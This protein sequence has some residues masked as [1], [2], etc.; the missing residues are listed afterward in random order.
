MERFPDP[1]N[2]EDYAKSLRNLDDYDDWEF[3]LEP[4]SKDTT[5][6]RL[7]KREGARTMHHA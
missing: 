4:I 5:W 6:V 7:D 1:R 2:D 3:G